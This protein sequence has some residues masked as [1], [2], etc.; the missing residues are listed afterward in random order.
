MWIYASAKSTGSAGRDGRR[1]SAC[2]LR[3]LVDCSLV[4]P[5]V[6]KMSQIARDEHLMLPLRT[7]LTLMLMAFWQFRLIQLSSV[8]T[9]LPATRALQQCLT[10]T[11]RH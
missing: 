4:A 10:T 6:A 7:E 5:F 2:S 9:A 11:A 3:F 8:M 1:L